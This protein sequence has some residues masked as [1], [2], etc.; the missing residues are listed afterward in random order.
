MRYVLVGLV[1]ACGLANA[2][3]W[4]TSGNGMLNG[5][6]YFRE[7]ILTSQEAVSFYGNIVF[8]G[9]GSH[10]IS[11]QEFYCSSECQA[12]FP[13]QSSGTYSIAGSGFGFIID[14][15]ISLAIIGS[16]GANGIFVGSSTEGGILHMFIAAPISGQGTATL[17]GNYT[18]SYLTPNLF[19]QSGY[20]FDALMQM[21]PN[22]AGTIGNVS[23]SAYSTSATAFNQT[24][25]GIKIFR[26]Q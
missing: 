17:N 11:A 9:N 5:N 2:Q 19:S 26:R 14:P 7:V 10:T 8:N 23:L 16:V 15:Q 1:A 20:A 12:P 3:T 25:P 22:G 13:Y 18:L 21:S 24:I 6:Y 4:D